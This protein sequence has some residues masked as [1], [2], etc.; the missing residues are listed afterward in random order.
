MGSALAQKAETGGGGWCHPQG[1]MDMV[2]ARLGCEKAIVE[3]H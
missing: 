2:A 3:M 1:D